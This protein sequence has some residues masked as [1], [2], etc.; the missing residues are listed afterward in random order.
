MTVFYITTRPTS[1]P[2]YTTSVD[3]A[4]SSAFVPAPFICQRQS[5]RASGCVHRG[6]WA[7]LGPPPA[8]LIAHHLTDRPP[9]P[10]LPGA[11]PPYRTRWAR[12]KLVLVGCRVTRRVFAD[13]RY[14]AQLLH[15]TRR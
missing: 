14:A 4:E 13:G 15:L 2:P 3:V 1:G 9:G 6:G 7:T 11:M 5:E 8:R 10:G 12:W